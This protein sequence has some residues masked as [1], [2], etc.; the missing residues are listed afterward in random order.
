MRRSSQKEFASFYHDRHPAS[1]VRLSVILTE[2]RTYPKC[3][4]VRFQIQN[5]G[6]VNLAFQ[7]KFDS[8]AEL[9]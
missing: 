6:Y 1:I 4:R 9:G 2:T 5:R 3:K 8:P 7:V